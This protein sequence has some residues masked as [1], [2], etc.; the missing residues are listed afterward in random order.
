MA[1][2]AIS[3]MMAS[4]MSWRSEK[5]SSSSMAKNTTAA[6]TPRPIEAYNESRDRANRTPG[7][8]SVTVVTSSPMKPTTP[9][10]AR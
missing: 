2:P 5:L 7:T 3:H 9:V 6:T 1:R 10:S 8:T 4:G